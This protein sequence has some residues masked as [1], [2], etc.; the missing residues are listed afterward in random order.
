MTDK[1]NATINTVKEL[2][3]GAILFQR[4]LDRVLQTLEEI[5]K[6]LTPQQEQKNIVVT[7]SKQ[8]AKIN[9]EDSE[10]KKEV[11]SPQQGYQ[12]QVVGLGTQ[13]I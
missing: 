2:K 13:K 11:K 8:Q 1:L 6:E 9:R 4:E 12:I 5:S 3:S 7:P 10:Q